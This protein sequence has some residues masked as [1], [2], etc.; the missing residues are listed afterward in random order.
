MKAYLAVPLTAAVLAGLVLTG[1][2]VTRAEYDECLAAARRAHDELRKT[3]G[4]LETTR[5]EKDKLAQQLA[6]RERSLAAGQEE[7]RILKAEKRD[8]RN[9]FKKLQALYE[10]LQREPTPFPGGP[11]LPPLVDTALQGF[12]KAN[13]QLVEYLPSYGMV[14]FKAD[15][16]FEKGKDDV[17][18]DAVK[19]LGKLTKI[20]NS[21][22][23]AVFH[24][25]VAGHTD[26]IPILKPATKRRHPNNWYLSVHR[27]VEVQKVLVKAGLKPQRIGAMGFGEYHPVEP[28]KANKKGNQKNRRVEIWIVPPDRLLAESATAGKAS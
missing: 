13:P 5:T 9:D 27:A 23:A 10:K 4:N 18:A 15:L 28:N 8:L 19:A 11:V 6:D 17:S 12:A 2:C 20:L 7:T 16:T 21:K 3:Q 1:G 24:V 22:V 26:D 25:Y 14:K